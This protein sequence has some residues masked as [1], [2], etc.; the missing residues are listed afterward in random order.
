MKFKVFIGCLIGILII[1]N[2][3]ESEFISYLQGRYG[4]FKS[5]SKDLYYNDA[6]VEGRTYNLFILSIYTTQNGKHDNYVAILGNFFKL[7]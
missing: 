5:T 2:P 7:D 1:T 3:N 4:Y 6:I